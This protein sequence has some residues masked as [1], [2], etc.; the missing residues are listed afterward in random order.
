MPDFTTASAAP[1][2]KSSLTLHWNLFHEFHP[3]GGVSARFAEGEVFCCAITAGRKTSA[4]RNMKIVRVVFM[5]TFLSEAPGDWYR[6]IRFTMPSCDRGGN[7]QID[8]GF[9]CAVFEAS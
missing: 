2:I 8:G 9:L 5:Q 6:K 7:R 1:L 4:Q 3:M